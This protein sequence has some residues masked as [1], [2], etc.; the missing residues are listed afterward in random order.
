MAIFHAAEVQAFGASARPT[1]VSTQDVRRTKLSDIVDDLRSQDVRKMDA[2]RMRLQVIDYDVADDLCQLFVS[3]EHVSVKSQ[4]AGVLGRIGARQALPILVTCATDGKESGETRAES[5]AAIGKLGGREWVPFLSRFL[6]DDQVDI[7]LRF[8][9]LSTLGEAG[10]SSVV[11]VIIQLLDPANPVM[12][13]EPY[14]WIWECAEALGKLGDKRA[15]PCLLKLAESGG[16]PEKVPYYA[17]G[18]ALMRL[19][20][21]EGIPL[22]I[23]HTGCGDFLV[24]LPVLEELLG[25]L[26]VARR[27]DDLEGGQ[28]RRDLRS[29][30][31]KNGAK[32]EWDSH[33]RIFVTNALLTK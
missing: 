25:A 22:Y 13:A 12:K 23:I 10:D 3:S 26:P 32:L 17:I 14:G 24:D 18:V 31:E 27:A 19:K 29:W 5:I 9:A 20:C 11:P 33:R 21:K 4:V 2:A 7:S 6:T 16:A 8:V 28:L 30:W 15:I 1:D